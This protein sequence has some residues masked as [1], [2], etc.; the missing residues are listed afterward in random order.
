MRKSTPRGETGISYVVDTWT[1]VEYFRG[2]AIGREMAAELESGDHYTS[3]ISVGEL[4]DKFAREYLNGIERHVEFIRLKT[5]VI[6]LSVEVAMRAGGNK[7]DHRATTDSQMGLADAII[8][9]SAHE[10]GATV[11]TGDPDFDGLDGVEMLTT[12]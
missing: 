10:V 8:Y 12:G 1:W 7:H 9:E 11:L 2:S 6:P 3:I 4:S 5:E